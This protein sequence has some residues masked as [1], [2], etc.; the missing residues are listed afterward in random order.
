MA[1]SASTGAPHSRSGWGFDN[2]AFTEEWEEKG[3]KI[4]EKQCSILHEHCLELPV[5]AFIEKY[6]NPALPVII[7]GIPKAESWAAVENWDLGKLNR[8]YRNRRLKCGEDGDG[9]SVRVK[10]KYFLQYMENQVDDSPLYIFDRQ[11][12]A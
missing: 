7:E 12:A 8:R 1:R 6:E 11:V 3:K 9:Y 2:F 4:D 10:L 5:Q